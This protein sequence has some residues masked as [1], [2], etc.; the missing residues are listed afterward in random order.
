MISYQASYTKRGSQK[1]ETINGTAVPGEDS[2]LFSSVVDQALVRQLDVLLN[3]EAGA[4]KQA[5]LGDVV[6]DVTVSVKL[7]I[8]YASSPQTI[9]KACAIGFLEDEIKRLRS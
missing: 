6:A 7:E 2:I 4:A 5:T 8:S 1:T 9:C 3:G